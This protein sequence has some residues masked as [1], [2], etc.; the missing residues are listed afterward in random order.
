MGLFDFLFPKK[1]KKHKLPSSLQ[2]LVG[3]THGN[4]S[5]YELAFTHKSS[6]DRLERE[7]PGKSN[8]RLEYLGDAILDAVVADFL[9]NAFPHEDEG[10]LTQVR[11]KF[12]SRVHLA[13]VA[14][15]V[16]LDQFVRTNLGPTDK[17]SS[18]YGNAFEALV[19]AVYLDKG[20]VYAAEFIK[21]TML[22]MNQV[23]AVLATNLDF[24]SKLLEL[25]QREGHEI[26]YKTELNT[27]GLFTSIVS[28]NQ[29][30]IATAEASNKKQAE[31]KA[32]KIALEEVL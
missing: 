9:F 11:S 3:Y 14:K 32:S 28:V 31:Q 21:S 17:T 13:Q 2:K 12:V 16:G 27:K 23:S 10:F 6:L 25:G 20:Y 5:F 30:P 1:Y 26:K 18:I 7:I 24:K 19:G 29:K 8:E 15:E 22:S 4:K